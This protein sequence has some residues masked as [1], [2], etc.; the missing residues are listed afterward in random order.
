[1]NAAKTVPATFT[2]KTYT[3]TTTAG[4]GGSIS[5]SG[6]VSV[7]H[8]ASQTFTITPNTNYG[9]ASVLVDGNSVGVVT[10]YTFTN[11]TANRTIAATFA[12]NTFTVTA[13]APG[14]NGTIVCDPTSVSYGGSSQC[15]ITPSAG[16]KLESLTDNNTDV[17]GSV[18]NNIYTISNVISGHTLIASFAVNTSVPIAVASVSSGSINSG[19]SLTI[20]HTT[21]GSDR[22]MLVGVSLRPTSNNYSVASIT[23]N[24]VALTKV[25]SV[26]RKSAARTEIWRLI[27][28]PTGTSNVVITFNSS[29]TSGAV[30]GVITFTGVNQTTPLGTFVSA[31]GSSGTASRNVSSAVGEMVFGVVDARTSSSLTQGAAQ[32]ERWDLTA[33]SG[34]SHGAGSTQQGAVAVTTAWS[35]GSSADWAI[36]AVPIKPAFQ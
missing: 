22:L 20:S 1:M 8:G 4:T 28:P 29:V 34:N 5:P 14:G 24:G 10:T 17:L 6:S 25:G 31:T 19:S 2:L 23:Y 36:G 16:Y 18:S 26:V 15:T 30:A 9:V 32:T 13:L 3:I 27:A 7:N 12:I 11:V 21:S 33:G 35:L